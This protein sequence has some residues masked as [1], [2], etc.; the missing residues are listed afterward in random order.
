M[1]FGQATPETA[2]RPFQGL[3]FST[4]LDTPHRTPMQPPLQLELNQVFSIRFS[5]SDV[6][7][8]ILAR[9]EQKSPP[10]AASSSITDEEKA[11]KIEEVEMEEEKKIEEEMEI[12]GKKLEK[13]MKNYME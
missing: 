1:P 8:S 12:K 7:A 2:L 3:L 6:D 11:D 9:M 4:V 10:H 5:P 13:E